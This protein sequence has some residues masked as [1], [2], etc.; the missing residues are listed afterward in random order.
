MATLPPQS[1][2]FT[3]ILVGNETTTSVLGALSLAATDYRDR[4][5]IGRRALLESVVLMQ[6][7]RQPITRLFEWSDD[8]AEALL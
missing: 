2:Q 8:N 7:L 1:T 4:Y 3:L 6:N 5:R